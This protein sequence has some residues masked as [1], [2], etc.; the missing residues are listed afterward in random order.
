MPSAE[1]A[2]ELSLSSS[3]FI[4]VQRQIAR[5]F[6]PVI[7]VLVLLTVSELNWAKPA[8]SQFRSSSPFTAPG[9]FVPVPRTLQKQ[10][11]E[12]KEAIEDSRYNDAVISLGDLL[13][14]VTEEGDEGELSSQDFFLDAGD[15]GVLAL[16]LA[17]AKVRAWVGG[18]VEKGK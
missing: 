12:A 18:W 2:I 7:L 16:A 17:L 13:A 4:V 6:K 5:L 3:G 11:R 8:Y 15:D 14:R 9:R 10:M 1:L